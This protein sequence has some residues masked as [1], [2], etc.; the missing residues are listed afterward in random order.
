[1]A[2]SSHSESLNRLLYVPTLSLPYLLLIALWLFTSVAAIA[3]PLSLLFGHTAARPG[4]AITSE[5][6]LRSRAPT[7]AHAG[8]HISPA[9]S[10]PHVL[11]P[12]CNPNHSAGRNL[13]CNLATG[14][15][16]PSDAPG[17]AAGSGAAASD[18]ADSGA[19]P[20][21]SG[22]PSVATAADG[23]G[24]CHSSLSVAVHLAV[25]VRVRVRV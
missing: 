24:G 1:M 17:A 20:A 13:A 21:G 25:R 5:H 23:A 9:I 19:A 16:P 12:G 18:A 15:S 14:H 8:R 4:N 10:P 7:T 2:E 22:A 3:S 6:N 11:S